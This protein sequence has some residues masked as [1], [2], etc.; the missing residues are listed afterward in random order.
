V[1]LLAPGVAL[2]VPEG[3]PGV[4]HRW[5]EPTRSRKRGW[6]LVSHPVLSPLAVRDMAA[7][8]AR[9]DYRRWA[10]R[11]RA[12]GGCAQPI[13][14]RGR[15]EYL[16]PATGEVLHRYTTAHESGGVLRVACKT[17]R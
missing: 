15:V 7:A 8:L 17:R 9:P 13:H 3:V 10:A 5:L 1:T 14:L 2:R 6:F 11:T 16:D 4:H 12:L